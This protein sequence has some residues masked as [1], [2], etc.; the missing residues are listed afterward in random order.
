VRLVVVPDDAPGHAGADVAV[1]RRGFGS[2]DD[3]LPSVLGVGLRSL[4]S[5]EGDLGRATCVVVGGPM[6]R[7]VDGQVAVPRRGFGSCDVESTADDE[8]AHVDRPELQSPEGDLGRATQSCSP[9]SPIVTKPTLSLQSPE[10]DLGR[11]TKCSAATARFNMQ[12]TSVAVPR[13]GF[14]SCDLQ[15]YA[16]TF[17]RSPLSRCSPPKGIWVVR[18]GVNGE[19]SHEV[20]GDHVAVPRR[21]FGSCDGTHIAR[22]VRPRLHHRPLQSPEGDLGRATDLKT[23]R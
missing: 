1:P 7:S 17:Q 14:G 13:R 6:G 15:N 16:V 3:D 23:S 10:G 2:C 8:L 22:N 11:A 9:T 5:P 18:R 20:H 4:Q 21:G 19:E 12:S